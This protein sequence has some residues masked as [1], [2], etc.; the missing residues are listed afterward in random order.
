MDKLKDAALDDWSEEATGQ[1]TLCHQ[2]QER[3]N[4]S[5]QPQGTVAASLQNR[6]GTRLCG[7]VP[8]AT[9]SC[10]CRPRSSSPSPTGLLRV[11]AGCSFP[12]L[13]ATLLAT[14]TKPESRRLQLAPEHTQTC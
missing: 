9:G 6:E 4:R 5:S 2:E 12:G 13:Q 1:G 10:V 11:R 7:S 3:K 8:L 14:A